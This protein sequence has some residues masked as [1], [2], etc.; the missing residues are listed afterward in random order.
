MSTYDDYN[1]WAEDLKNNQVPPSGL[2]NLSDE[3][4]ATIQAAIDRLVSTGRTL[5]TL[6]VLDGE[7]EHHRISTLVAFVEGVTS[8]A[9]FG[10]FLLTLADSSDDHDVFVVGSMVVAGVAD[11]NVTLKRVMEVPVSHNGALVP[12]RDYV[13][14]DDFDFS[15]AASFA[16][17]VIE[18]F[19]VLTILV[20]IEVSS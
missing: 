4:V 13:M 19:A 18:A 20:S 14:L 8:L 3:T 15:L 2:V 17:P 11:L 7:T 16:A 9:E 12:F 10:E 6:G 5:D 1:S